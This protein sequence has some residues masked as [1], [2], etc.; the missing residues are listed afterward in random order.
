MSIDPSKYLTLSLNRRIAYVRVAIN[1]DT[2]AFEVNNVTN[3]MIQYI[4]GGNEPLTPAFSW[5]ILS[6]FFANNGLTPIFYD[7]KKNWGRRD[8][9]TGV[10]HGAVGMVYLHV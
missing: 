1:Q 5:E 10:W 8:E 2:S 4:S 7:C 3:K 6:S 9:D